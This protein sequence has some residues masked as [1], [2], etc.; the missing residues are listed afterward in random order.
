V[1][2]QVILPRVDMDM[3]E[4]RIS[5]WYVEEG[6]KVAKDQP[7]FEIETDKAA[8][9][10][11]APASGVIRGLSASLDVPL[12]VG[13]IIAWIDAEGE[14]GAPTALPV[15]APGEAQRSV[16]VVGNAGRAAASAVPGGEATVVRPEATAHRTSLRATP[17][18]RRLARES[19]VD[20]ISVPGSGPKGRV[21]AA[22]IERAR[23]EA[24]GATELSGK[25]TR[26]K[27]P[28]GPLHCEWL[29]R[30][31]GEPLVL[32]HG[33]GGDLNAWRLFLASARPGWPVLG[34]DLPGHGGSAARRIASFDGMVADVAATLRAE[35]G[36]PVH[37]AGHSL[38]GAV[39]TALAS[40]EGFEA[41]SLLLVATAGLGPEING[42]FLSGFL[43]ARTKASLA[44]WIAQLT[45]DPAA[46]GSSFVEASLRQRAGAQMALDE[47]ASILFPDGTQAFS[48]RSS[49]ERL[50]IPVKIVFGA[51][52]RIIPA[53]HALG[54]PGHV[55][56]HAFPGLG[57]MPHL[58]APRVVA[59][60]LNELM[61]SASAG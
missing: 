38:G 18:A 28:L 16:S 23:C 45:L 2:T 4:G 13:S 42:A 56:V 14:T 7:I 50:T 20:L 44:P 46:L 43:R 31:E 41:R 47:V 5:R 25:A 32:L 53:H 10:V 24:E 27:H 8:M 60:L 34:I 12:P 37:L 6:A 35:C 51:E 22:D 57:H 61:R 48:I 26:A 1:P 49:F 19:G 52:D 17:L 59:R 54:L 29:R 30:G 58:E 40:R 9:E 3:A 33:F 21:Q 36:R 15:S 55:A 11:E 39:A